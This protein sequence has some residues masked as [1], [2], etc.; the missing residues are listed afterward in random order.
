MNERYAAE[1]LKTFAQQ[2]LIN[3][4]LANERAAVVAEILLEGDL[5]GHTTHGLQLLSAYLKDLE[6]GD[7][8][9]EGEPTVVNDYGHIVTWD[10]NFLPGPWVVVKAIEQSLRVFINTN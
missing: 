5:M 6:N 1:Q 3:A 10:A 7:M 9:K 2:L 8:T 4:G